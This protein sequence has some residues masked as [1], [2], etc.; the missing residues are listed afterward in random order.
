MAFVR[1]RP[2]CRFCADPEESVV[3]VMREH[4]RAGKRAV[5]ERA[6]FLEMR[7]LGSRVDELDGA[8]EPR[9]RP[10]GESAFFDRLA[11]SSLLG[12][13]AGVDAAARKEGAVPRADQGEAT[14]AILD[15]GVGTGPQYTGVDFRTGA[16]SGGCAPIDSGVRHRGN[17]LDAALGCD[18]VAGVKVDRWGTACQIGRSSWV[19]MQLSH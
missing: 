12:R 17:V 16:E 11:D 6:S 1:Q 19:L 8:D 15:D 2:G 10:D 5:D 7:L 18:D 14:V 13:F 4:T 9:A 3:R